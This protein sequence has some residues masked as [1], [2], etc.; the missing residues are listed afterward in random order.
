MYGS[1]GELLFTHKQ[2]APGILEKGAPPAARLE[3][4]RAHKDAAFDDYRPDAD[5]AVRRPG[6]GAD[7]QDLF[8]ADNCQNSTG[9]KLLLGNDVTSL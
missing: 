6:P 3:T 2:A 5:D 9:K 7:A 1:D 4:P 8:L